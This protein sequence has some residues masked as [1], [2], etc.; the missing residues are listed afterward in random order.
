[1]EWKR[2]ASCFLF[3]SSQNN[4][5]PLGASSGPALRMSKLWPLAPHEWVVGLVFCVF[6]SGIMGLLLP[7]ALALLSCLAARHLFPRVEL[8]NSHDRHRMH[9]IH[10]AKSC[11][12]CLEAVSNAQASSSAQATS[13]SEYSCTVRSTMNS[14]TIRLNLWGFFRQSVMHAPLIQ[15][16]QTSG[17]ALMQ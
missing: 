5:Q 14:R 6:V 9:L 13:W 12:P 17:L 7:V 11:S 8:V 3:E 4:E 15:L 2:P 10:L 1:L 16:T